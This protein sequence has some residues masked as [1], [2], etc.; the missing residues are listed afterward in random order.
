MISRTWVG[1]LAG[2]DSEEDERQNFVIKD[3]NIIIYMMIYIIY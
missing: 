3:L 2:L 1:M